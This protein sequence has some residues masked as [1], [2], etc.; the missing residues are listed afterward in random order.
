[1]SLFRR[2]WALGSRA[3]IDREIEDELNAH[4]QMRT[5]DNAAAGMPAA[6]ARRD[7]VL[8][9]GN[10]TAMKERV[11]GVDTALS[12]DNLWNDIRFAGRRLRKSPGFSITAIL[13]LAL[14]IGA[15]TA[16]FSA[17]YALLL[18]S[19]PFQH[20]DRIVTISETHPQIAGGGEVTF[21]DYLD[22]H[23]QQSSFEQMA[24]YS[25]VSPETVSLVWDGH[26]EQVHKVLAS[27]SLFSLLGVTPSLGRTFVEQDDNPNANHV[28]VISAEAWQRYF[29][30]DRTIIGRNVD[31]NGVSYT[32][33]GVLP[34][35]SAYP[36]TGEF[37]MP[38][39]LM[40]KE[41]RASVSGIRSTS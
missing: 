20:A 15:T 40:D 31:L 37:W 21:P 23:S 12:I 7:A 13:T 3:R 29:G 39:S 10:P 41:S 35:G 27:S 2:M 24:G 30:A 34:P 19:L 1:M 18:R 22:W 8:R 6:E 36:A 32:I 16:I 25:I 9:F 38:L 33:I 4:I 14:G 28:A 5:A 17:A 11:A 26:A